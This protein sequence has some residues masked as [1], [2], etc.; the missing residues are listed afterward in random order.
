[1]QQMHRH[2]NEP[3]L[4]PT[5][6]PPYLAEADRFIA[7]CGRCGEPAPLNGSSAADTCRACGAPLDDDGDACVEFRPDPPRS[8]QLIGRITLAIL[9]A[10]LIIAIAVALLRSGS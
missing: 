8:A 9:A 5:T 1:M 10:M 3:R 7:R 6:D 4:P 2:D